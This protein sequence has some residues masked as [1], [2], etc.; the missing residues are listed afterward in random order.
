MSDPLFVYMHNTPRGCGRP[1][2]LMWRLPEYASSLKSA[3]ALH[4]DGRPI[5]FGES[6]RCDT[7]GRVLIMTPSTHDIFPLSVAAFE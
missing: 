3:D 1:G 6:L 4:L 2:W 5:K 7:C